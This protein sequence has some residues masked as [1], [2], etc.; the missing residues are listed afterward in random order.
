MHKLKQ[1]YTNSRLK[2]I[3]ITVASVTLLVIGGFLLTRDTNP[4]PENIR[5]KL[6]FSPFLIHSNSTEYKATNYRTILTEDKT[7]TTAFVYSIKI[8]ESANNVTVTQ[9]AQPPQ[10]FEIPEYKERFLSNGILQYD[11]VQ[12]TNGIIYLGKLSKQSNEQI[13]IMLEKGLIL[14]MKPVKEL[15]KTD[16]HKLGEQFYIQKTD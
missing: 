15:S 6:T 5:Q 16:W 1:F 3:F 13:G 9:Y 7:E 10:F 11:T 14:F 12:T 8:A 4:I 2:L